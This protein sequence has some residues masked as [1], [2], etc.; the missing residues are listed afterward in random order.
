MSQQEFIFSHSTYVQDGDF[1]DAFALCVRL[2]CEILVY[3]LEVGDGDILF[4]LFIEDYVVVNELN[5]TS[6]VVE[7]ASTLCTSTSR[8]LGS[9]YF[10]VFFYHSR[11][12]ILMILSD[13][14]ISIVKFKLT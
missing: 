14:S 2:S 1:V 3:V 12:C 7:R 11:K 9:S 5:L 4:E 13:F 8:L 6:E 10:F